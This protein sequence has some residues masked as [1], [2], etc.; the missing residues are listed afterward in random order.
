M[1]LNLRTL[2]MALALSG[3]LG[4]TSPAHAAEPPFH[5]TALGGMSVA[6]F[7]D[8][9]DVLQ[10]LKGLSAGIGL[11]WS[12][13]PSLEFQPQLLY[14]EKGVSY[15]ESELTDFAGTPL[16]KIETLLVT[17][18][19]EVPVLVRWEVPTGGRVHPVLFGG[20]FASFELSEKMKITGS[21]E[22]SEDSHS[23]KGGDIGIALGGG[24]EIDAGPGRWVIEGRYD[25]G[26]VELSPDG[27]HSGAWL[28][29]TGYRF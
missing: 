24:L 2:P 28:V 1:V 20:P 16:G 14:V 4:T 10:S 18:A 27:S 19:L 3:A 7:R 5:I 8:A 25:A 9:P 26:T 22:T 21:F 13:G 29:M 23:L 15:G 6:K 12:I 17:A 11:G